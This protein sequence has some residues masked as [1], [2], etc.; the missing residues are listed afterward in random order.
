MGR[1]WIVISILIFLFISCEKKESIL[2]GV[3]VN[4]NFTNDGDYILYDFREEYVYCS[5]EKKTEKKNWE[6]DGNYLLLEDSG[7]IIKYEMKFDHNNELELRRSKDFE[8][9]FLLQDDSFLSKPNVISILKGTTWNYEVQGNDSYNDNFLVNEFE[10]I[11][12]SRVINYYLLQ[13]SS[14]HI[15]VLNYELINYKEV[16]VLKIFG[17]FDLYFFI[18]EAN[19]K[20]L[21]AVNSKQEGSYNLV[22]FIAS[23]PNVI[24][25]G[26]LRNT[27]SGNW[28]STD[29]NNS[30]NSILFN[31]EISNYIIDA[32]KSTF[33]R[34]GGFTISSNNKL[35]IMYGSNNDID[36]IYSIEMISDSALIISSL[37]NQ[38][39]P[40]HTFSRVFD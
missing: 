26:N 13:D 22:K 3:W 32:K 38:A 29:S 16:N 4:I 36:S 37:T 23:G 15:N 20:S 34:E 21:V 11:D 1:T 10:F 35:L 27:I 31:S 28:I 5:D 9:I 19:E 33:L 17:A 24:A 6:I 8:S 2:S 25:T 40:N 7:T 39:L 18:L 30:I 12:K 14:Q